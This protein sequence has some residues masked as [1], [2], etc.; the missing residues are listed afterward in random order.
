V[1][2]DIRNN[3]GGY[4]NGY[5]L[6]VFTRRNYLM[7]TQRGEFP[8]PS[9]SALGQRS[10][11][12]PTVLVTNESSLSDAEDFTEGY[13]ALGVGKV[14]GEPTAGWII[15]TDG[16]ALIDGSVVRLPSVRVQD[17]RGQ[18][19]E[20]HPRPVDLEVARPLGDSETG[21]DPQ[22]DAAVKVLLDQIPAPR[23][24]P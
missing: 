24:G 17:L 20:M 5:A 21:R 11:G 9:R 23:A 19:M 8:V 16:Q 12:L 18:T 15:Y 10:L 14:V 3:N 22:L 13:R 6:D 4:M 2:I 1:V 7:M